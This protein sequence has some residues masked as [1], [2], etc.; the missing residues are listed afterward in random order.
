MAKNTIKLKKYL[1]IIEEYVATAVE[2]TPGMLLEPTSGG[3]IQAHSTKEGDAL[4]MFALEDELQG[5]GIDDNYAVSVPVQVWIPQRGEQVYALLA[6]GET[7]VIGSFLTSN[8]DGKLKVYASSSG[9]WEYPLS[10]V[11][12]AL[13]AIDMSGSSAADPTG[14]IS[15]RVV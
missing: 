15:V 1:D 5:N 13:D 8:G 4:V 14:R 6:D 11:A 3:L 7:A 9:S 2:I 12:Q 10:I